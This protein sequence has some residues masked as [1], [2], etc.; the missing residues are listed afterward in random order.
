MTN[1]ENILWQAPEYLYKEKS[2]DWFWSIG[3]ITF[4][5]AISAYMFGNILLVILI[6]LCGIT[7]ALFGAR[8]PKT[9][10][11]EISR[12]GIRADSILYPFH[13]LQSFWILEKEREN[14]LLLKSQKILAQ[15]INIPL[16]DT[17]PDQVQM[18]LENF[19]PGEEDNEPLAERIMNRLGF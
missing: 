9:I 2:S 8:K 11:F 12:K 19:I 16:G 17:D 15:Q 13:N 10:S 18:F 3:I 6:L 4:A 7:L 1:N 14:I 5:G